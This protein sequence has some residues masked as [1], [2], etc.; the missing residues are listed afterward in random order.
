MSKVTKL[1]AKSY[2]TSKAAVKKA[3]PARAVADAKKR[4]VQFAKV[5]GFKVFGSPI[6]PEH[7][8]TRQIADAVA[9]LF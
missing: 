1:G 5:G 9:S 2:S 4:R 8:T 6:E 3:A 7:K